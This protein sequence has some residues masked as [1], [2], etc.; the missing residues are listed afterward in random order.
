MKIFVMYG[1]ATLTELCCTLNKLSCSLKTM[2]TLTLPPF[3]LTELH[4]T[5][6]NCCTLNPTELCSTITVLRCTLT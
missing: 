1:N 2:L 3:A 4:C 5:L 6:L